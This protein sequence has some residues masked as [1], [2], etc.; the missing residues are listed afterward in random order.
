MAGFTNG[1]GA[2]GA[3][4]IYAP[5]G[6]NVSPAY[7]IGNVTTDIDNTGSGTTLNAPVTTEG[8]ANVMQPY[9]GLNYIIALE[10]IVPV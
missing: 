9:L 1:G 6:A 4:N 5:I 2:G 3:A 10:G 8:S 7:D